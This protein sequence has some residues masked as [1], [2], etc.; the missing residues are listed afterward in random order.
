[1]NKESIN[2]C[3]IDLQ[4]VTGIEG[5]KF[6]DIKDCYN[7]KSKDKAKDGYTVMRIVI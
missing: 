2:S 7:P 3:R 6:Q 4:D 5:Y 1:V